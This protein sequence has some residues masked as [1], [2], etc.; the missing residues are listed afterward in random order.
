MPRMFRRANIASLAL[1]FVGVIATSMQGTVV[2]GQ[3]GPM[4]R[5]RNRQPR[6]TPERA[7]PGEAADGGDV[8]YAVAPQLIQRVPGC[9][10]CHC[11]KVYLDVGSNIGVQVRKLF[12][13]SKFP[14]APVHRYFDQYFGQDRHD[15]CAIGFEPNPRHSHEL[16]Q[17]EENYRMMGYNVKFF[18]RTAVV[19]E[20]DGVA[21]FHL[22][23]LADNYKAMGSSL[24]KNARTENR[25]KGKE[26][27]AVRT[28]NL[29][30]FIQ[31]NISPNATVV[32]KMDIE[33]AE[34]TVF[35]QLLMHGILCQY[36][37]FAFVEWHD[38]NGY[39]K[40]SL[41]KGMLPGPDPADPD[42]GWM[43][44]Q[45]MRFVEAM[46]NADPECNFKLTD[47]D[48]ESHNS[49]DIGKRP[50]PRLIEKPK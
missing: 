28:L 4:P 25:A 21:T 23:P 14:R 45:I 30:R 15:V 12:E 43:H 35:P 49:Q 37:D 13:P 33:G 1:L 41:G 18:T 7:T 8:G 34:F 5:R 42:K 6:G 40:N 27:E 38:T 47:L 9:Q 36:I 2:M 50:L 31:E 20:P 39:F 11:T 22:A 44:Q 3:N 24:I 32:M 10:F 46:T 19:A 48:D 17:I 29:K 26:S 16:R